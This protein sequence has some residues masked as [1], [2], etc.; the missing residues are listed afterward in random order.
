MKL[1]KTILEQ[2]VEKELQLMKEFAPPGS[3]IPRK[4]KPGY[5]ER[6]PIGG[7]EYY[8][9]RD[10]ADFAYG[11]DPPE[12]FG[13]FGNFYKELEGYGLTRLLGRHGADFKFGKKHQK[14]WDALRDAKLME[15]FGIPQ[16][17]KPGM[18]EPKD[19]KPRKRDP[20]DIDEIPGLPPEKLPPDPSRWDLPGFQDLREIVHEELATILAESHDSEGDMA[21]KQLLKINEYSNMLMDLVADK[22]DLPEWV[23]SKLAVLAD[24]IGEVY[25]HMHSEE[26]LHEEVIE[27]T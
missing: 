10:P 23:Q 19:P 22:R 27:E 6:P 14:A 21:E 12:G 20:W 26:T 24:D 11:Y 13:G 25:H 1:T 17:M 3:L 8:V 15:R 9:E 4:R 16:I 18:Y 7:G 2:L 5:W